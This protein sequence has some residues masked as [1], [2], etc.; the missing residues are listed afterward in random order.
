[1]ADIAHDIFSICS[2]PLR[3]YSDVLPSD[4]KRKVTPPEEFY[5]EEYPN[6]Y[7]APKDYER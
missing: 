1:M 5:Q 7:E 6:E 4:K 3:L 2:T